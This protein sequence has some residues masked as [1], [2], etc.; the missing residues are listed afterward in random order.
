MD[1]FLSVAGSWLPL[2]ALFIPLIHGLLIKASAAHS[3]KTIANI[4]LSAVAALAYQVDS[5][6]GILSRETATAWGM[7]LLISITTYL[8]VWKPLDVPN[9]IA[10]NQ[11][12]G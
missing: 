3:V 10:P 1:N 2:I 7:A 9:R 8:G 4:V 5:G 12:L 6:G 11:G